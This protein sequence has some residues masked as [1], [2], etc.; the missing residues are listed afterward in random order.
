MKA[1]DILRYEPV[2]DDGAYDRTPEGG[3]GVVLFV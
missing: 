1:Y 3:S 2:P